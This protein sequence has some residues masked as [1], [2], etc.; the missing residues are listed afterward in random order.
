MAAGQPGSAAV[1]VAAAPV[2]VSLRR[3]LSLRDLVLFGLVTIQLTA[4]MP[5]YGGLYNA[6]NGHTFLVILLSMVA[7]LLTA[8]SYGRMAAAYPSAGSAFSYVGQEIHPTA[9]YVTGWSVTMDYMLIPIL[10]TMICSKTA[11]SFFPAVPFP[12]WAVFF[13]GLMSALNLRGIQASPRTNMV[14][15][16]VMAVVI[17]LFL[18]VVTRVVLTG[19]PHP[20]GFFTKPIYDPATFS[21]N[22]LFGGTAISVLTYL[23]FDAISTL[24][25]EVENPRRSILLAT[26]YS[27]LLIGGLSAVQ[28]YAAQL[29][30]PT[31]PGGRFT[32]VET[33]FAQV[34]GHVGGSW[35][36]TVVG[37]TVLIATFG[38]GLGSQLG[39]ARVLYAMGRSGTL[40]RTF[41]GALHPVRR[42]P[43]Y[44]VLFIGAVALSGALLLYWL[45]GIELGFELVNFGALLAFMG[46]NA[47]AFVH[48]GLRARRKTLSGLVPSLLGMIICAYLWFKL[49]N[50]ALVVGGVWLVAGLAL[51]ALRTR[52]FRRDLVTFEAKTEP[53]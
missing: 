19:G 9:G 18:G 36:F 21:W 23:G 35:L 42:V 4:P 20:A 25:E 37:A 45:E 17:V 12:A 24:A 51:G 15:A 3:A 48:Y 16:A 31:L 34:A 38:S 7:V 46:V 39:A 53:E 14:L 52:G 50:K 22:A 2:Q 30:G 43:H 29:V 44:S 33:A 49:G 1:A 26:V 5:I 10:S 41:F 28:V 32:E 40:P 8:I 27:C 47:A 13:V 11:A 6:S